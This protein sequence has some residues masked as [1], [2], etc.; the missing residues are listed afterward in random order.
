MSDAIIISVEEDEEL[1]RDMKD[2]IEKNR[3][4]YKPLKYCAER[5]PSKRGGNSTCRRPETEDF[6]NAY[7]M[8]SFLQTPR[9]QWRK[10]DVEGYE[11]I[12]D[13]IRL[14]DRERFDEEWEEKKKQEKE[15]QIRAMVNKKLTSFISRKNRKKKKIVK[16]QKIV[17][18]TDPRNTT[19]TRRRRRDLPPAPKPRSIYLERPGLRKSIP[20][21]MKNLSPRDKTPIA[22]IQNMRR[23][24]EEVGF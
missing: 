3:K 9:K 12:L 17:S 23:L 14:K 7:K 24:E 15:K 13:K 20:T 11:K 19:G 4:K 8:H 22:N 16:N 21:V 5:N 6:E 10:P 2:K 1:T 18:T